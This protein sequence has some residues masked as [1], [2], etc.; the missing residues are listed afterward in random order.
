MLEGGGDPAA[1]LAEI[2]REPDPD[3]RGFTLALANQITGHPA[4]ADKWIS[5]HQSMDSRT[6]PY[7]LAELH[8][9]RG[10]ND[11]AFASLEQAYSRHDSDIVTLKMDLFLEKLRSDPRFNA[12]L[13]KLKLP[14]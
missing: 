7:N 13:R 6:E 9:V 11:L 4:E 10:E 1:A 8:A 14:E 3:T 5:A 2:A 12:L